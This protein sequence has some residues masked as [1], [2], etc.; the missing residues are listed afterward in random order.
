MKMQFS[1]TLV[2]VGF[3]SALGAGSAFAGEEKVVELGEIPADI[4]EVAKANLVGLKLAVDEPGSL[5]DDSEIDD[6][7]V[8]HYKDLGEVQLVSANTETEA[9]GSF[10]YEIQGT[11]ADGRKIEIDIDPDGGVEEIEIEF[12]AD[13][14]PGAVMKA[15][16]AKLPGFAPEFIEASHAP[17]MQVIGYEF[18]G[19][20][21]EN[22]MDIEVSPD[23]R[24]ITVA[25]Q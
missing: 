17:S 23:G 7:I 5:D 14:V 12:Q 18:V 16:A 3:A 11:V 25:D 15:L 21:G 20:S 2:A 10:V 6:N 19:M 4:M 8:L 1:K 24:N 9:D 22:K 13:D